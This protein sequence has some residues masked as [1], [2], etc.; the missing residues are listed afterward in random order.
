MKKLILSGII[1][2]VLN[3][4][5]CLK[6]DAMYFTEREASSIKVQEEKVIAASKRGH[7]SGIHLYVASKN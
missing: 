5:L 4:D 7:S 1:C 6:L 3:P 2:A